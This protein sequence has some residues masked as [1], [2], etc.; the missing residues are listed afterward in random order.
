MNYGNDTSQCDGKL[1]NLDTYV[2]GE[3]KE[4]RALQQFE[5]KTSG[6]K[7][8][9]PLTESQCRRAAKLTGHSFIDGRDHN[10]KAIGHCYRTSS[11]KYWTKYRLKIVFT[12]TQ[13]IKYTK[14]LERDNL[15]CGWDRVCLCQ[16]EVVPT[17]T[18]A[19][20]TRKR[21]STVGSNQF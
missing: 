6:D 9:V 2:K 10:S 13:Y 18:P 5:V 12:N 16:K 19:A 1:N 7:C 14:T 21:F 4:D 8:R 17:T 20:P 3:C 15:Q 11:N